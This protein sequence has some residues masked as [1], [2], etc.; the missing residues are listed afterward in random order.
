MAAELG[1]DA[2]GFVFA[3]S[4]RRVTVGAVAAMTRELAVEFSEVER[5]GVFDAGSA[6]EIV[7]AARAAGLTGVQLHGRGNFDE[8][9]LREVVERAGGLRVIPVLHWEVGGDDAVAARVRAGLVAARAAGVER[10]LLDS[11]LGDAAGGTG[12]AFGWE[13]AA[14]G[15]A[16]ARGEL[17]LIVAGGLRAE[18]VAEAARAL[19]PWGVDVAS[20]VEAEPGRKSPE[21]VRAF[22]KAS[23]M[24]E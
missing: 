17:K 9:L 3:E 1:A 20:G 13:D 23:T 6:E 16:E 22:L 8:A 24:L 10:V 12:V 11:K 14:L 19:R 15:I 2:V 21:R 18:N 7:A 5:I 4:K